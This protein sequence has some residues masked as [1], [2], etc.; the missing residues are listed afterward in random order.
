MDTLIG[1]V[2]GLFVGAAVGLFIGALAAIAQKSDN[3]NF[4]DNERR[5]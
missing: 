1:F 3:N 4:N 2:I 5:Q